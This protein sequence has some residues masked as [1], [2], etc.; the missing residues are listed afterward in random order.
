M[1]TGERQGALGEGVRLLQMAGRQMRLPQRETTLHLAFSSFHRRD[2]LYR[3]REERHGVGDGL[4]MRAPGIE[5]ESPKA[6]DL[7][8]PTGV[9]QGHGEERRDSVLQGFVQRQHVPRRL[10]PDRARIVGILIPEIALEQLDDWEVGRRFPILHRRALENQPALDVRRVE[11]LVDQARLPHAG[12]T[13]GPDHL[14]TAGASLLQGLVEGVELGVASAR[15][16]APV[17]SETSTGA[18]IPLIGTGPRVFTWM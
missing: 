11:E 18:V 14:A 2:L 17:T 5:M 6:R 3:L 1:H 10:G 7:A 4:V 12:F 9:V 16:S 15:A 8:Q 13:H